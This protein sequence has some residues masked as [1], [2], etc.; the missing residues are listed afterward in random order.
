M[1]SP[2]WIIALLGLSLGM[3]PRVYAQVGP[4][5]Y[6]EKIGPGLRPLV[7][8]I[9]THRS[10][11]R[12][13]DQGMTETFVEHGL[14]A[15]PGEVRWNLKG[16]VQVDLTFA[17][18]AQRPDQAIL[19]SALGARGVVSDPYNAVVEM[20]VPPQN[21]LKAASLPGLL[22]VTVPHYAVV[23]RVVSWSSNP[24]N[25]DTAGS[26]ALGAVAY[27][28]ATGATGSGIHVGVISDGAQSYQSDVSAGYLPKNI[29]IDPN[30]TA[31]GS[32]G[33]EGSAM[34]QIV[35][36]SAPGVDLGFCGPSTDVQ[37]LS[38]LHD[39]EGTGFKAN[40]IVDDLGF[41]GVAMFQNGAF[42]TGVASFAQSNPNV[43]LV[44]AAGND[45]GA[46]WQGSWT[47]FTL[48]TPLTLNGVTYTQA[49]NFG[50]SSLP[51]TYAAISLQPND[52]DYWVLEWA[53]PWQAPVGDY[54]VVVYNG[55][56]ATTGKIVACNQGT[57][58]DSNGCTFTTTP[59]TSP[60]PNP[61][62]G[63]SYKNTTSSS[64]KLYI[65]VLL[66]NGTNPSGLLKLITGSQAS[67]EVILN[68]NTPF[69]S[70]YGQSALPQEFTAG[71]MDVYQVGSTSATIESFSSKGPVEFE[72][73]SLS[74]TTPS[75]SSIPKPDITGV[76]G[77]TI[78]PVG[79]FTS[80]FF[81]TS[82]AA[83]HIAALL[84]LLMQHEPGQNPE[85][86]VTNEASLPGG[87]PSTGASNSYGAGVP[88]LAKLTPSGQA[89]CNPNSTATINITS[90]GG[91]SSS[92]SSSSGGGGG[93]MNPLVLLVLGVL[94]LTAVRSRRD[95]AIRHSDC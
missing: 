58:I 31:Y 7:Q 66:R 35:Y 3:A 86:T 84:A 39:F 79:S 9:E 87:A 61:V 50:S 65:E 48:S 73:S 95:A 70:I 13:R 23:R 40:I 71:A 41:P 75:P 45:N 94:L 1:K 2:L 26:N 93:G 28:N 74:S 17:H 8:A 12:V 16:D 32:S 5:P 92:S 18:R 21:L 22:S 14:G 64:E 85:T 78:N 59:G 89:A 55:N 81:G 6:I 4:S 72:Y 36:D 24:P 20:W 80:P 29:F 10:L 25:Y 67:N 19:I 56:P 83:P 69:G 76:D 51:N 37:F 60:G 46:Y 47:P 52:T 54:D 42:A 33:N 68:P 77:V 91:G 63:N 30:D 43:H 11:A 88:C 62:Q 34:M 15:V 57:D 53:D 38:C 90:G 82:A 44:T 27:A 49:N